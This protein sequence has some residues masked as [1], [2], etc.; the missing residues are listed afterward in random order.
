MEKEL[1]EVKERALRL[2]KEKADVITDKVKA[3][4]RTKQAVEVENK[5][6]QEAIELK[7]MIRQFNV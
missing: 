2:A 4:E 3:E 5:A 1:K 7:E 6:T